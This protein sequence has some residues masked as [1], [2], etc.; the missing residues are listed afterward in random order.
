LAADEK[1]QIC[2]NETAAAVARIAQVQHELWCLEY[3]R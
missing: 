3:V 1:L 2:N